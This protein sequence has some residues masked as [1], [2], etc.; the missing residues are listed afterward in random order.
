MSTVNPLPNHYLS[1]KQ[2]RQ[3]L[4]LLITKQKIRFF[5][6]SPSRLGNRRELLNGKVLF[7]IKLILNLILFD[8]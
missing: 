1:P 8:V 5:Q 7:N 4:H 6:K 3:I 2:S